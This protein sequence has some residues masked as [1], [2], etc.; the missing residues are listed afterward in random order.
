MMLT[1]TLTGIVQPRV[2]SSTDED[3]RSITTSNGNCVLDNIQFVL[4]QMIMT[5]THNFPSGG[6]TKSYVFRP[7]PNNPFLIP[8]GIK[9]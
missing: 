4:Q 9:F 2:V 5:G 6:G 1:Q 8:K 7:P 3:L